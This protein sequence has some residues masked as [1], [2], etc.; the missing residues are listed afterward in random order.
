MKIRRLTGARHLGVAATAALA[1]GFVGATPAGAHPSS[2]ASVSYGVLTIVGT[3]RSDQIALGLAAGDPNTL[4][5]DFG[6]NG[7]P[8][9]SFDRTTFTAI[10]VLLRSGDDEFSVVQTN[11]AFADEALTV[12]GGSGDDT[13]TTG[14]GN[15]NIVAGAGNDLIHSGAG[16]DMIFGGS[17]NDF[18]NGGRGAD[19]ASLGSGDDSFEWNPG[20]GSDTIDGQ[21]GTDAL[22]FN[23]AALNETMSLSADGHRAV[24]LRDLGSI[25][26]D[27]DNVEVLSLAALG[28]TDNITINDM[29]GTDFQRANVNLGLADGTSDGQ[30]DSV[31]VSGTNDADRVEVT[32]DGTAVDV[33]G[34]P[35]ETTITGADTTDK[36]QVN[37]QDGNDRVQ[38][39]PSATA[40]IGVAVDLGAGQL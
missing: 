40:L 30:L 39:D 3:S 38:V 36:L 25:R 34:L 24:F 18:V 17:G 6:P 31:I 16:D 19:A 7:P 14:D 26:M 23:G 4:Q 33:S 2:S 1:V 37:T 22:V 13:I 15:D 11:G 5:V 10:S 35:T 9:Q 12:R 27:M 21:S 8:M 32:G 28:G 29:S 20:E